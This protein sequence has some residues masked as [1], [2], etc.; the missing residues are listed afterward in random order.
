MN[1]FFRKIAAITLAVFIIFTFCSCGDDS[2]DAVIR[3]EIDQ[4]PKTLDPQLAESEAELLAVRNIYEGLFRLDEKGEAVKAACTDYTVSQDRLIYTFS[5]D[6]NLQWKDKTPLTAADFVYALRR[7]VDP[8]T[9]APLA[10]TLACIKNAPEIL[11][12]K[13]SVDELGVVAVDEHTLSIEL[14]YDNPEFLEILASPIAMPCNEAFFLDTAGRYGMAQETVLSNGSFRAYQWQDK[15]IR[16]TRCSDYTGR[17]TAKCAAVLLILEGN[18]DT[19]ARADRIASGSID[20]GRID[21]AQLLAANSDRLGIKSF[22]DVCYMLVINPEASIG[23]KDIVS[24][25]KKAFDHSKI[26]SEENPYLTV[27]DSVVP[28]DL[29]ISGSGYSSGQCYLFEYDP[30]SA[31]QQLLDSVKSLSGEK[32]PSIE[33]LYPD[34]PGMKEVVTSIALDWQTNLGAYVNIAPDTSDGILSKVAASDYQMA[35]V[36]ITSSDSSVTKFFGNFKTDGMIAEFS[37]PALDSA[38]AAL[39]NGRYGTQA[40][41]LAAECE[42]LLAE[43]PYFTPLVFGHTHYATSSNMSAVTFSLS[44]GL[45]DLWCAVKKG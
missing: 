10:S 42:R 8:V 36:P 28:N 19:E 44:G 38:V 21:D 22:E 16:L 23:N 14:T 9:K 32:L 18:E 4:M 27:C 40:T 34:I 39:E 1:L 20:I 26:K 37:D 6:K 31:K 43:S 3:V 2:A 24:V 41:A 5:L 45:S 17:F 15:N 7:G 25:W 33:L 11:S 30:A 35:V 13:R 29:S 12:G